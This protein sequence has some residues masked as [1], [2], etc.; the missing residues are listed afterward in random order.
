VIK[1]EHL[2]PQTA[3]HL[4]LPLDVVT[5]ANDFFWRQGVRKN[6]SEANYRSVFVRHLG[7]I[8]ISRYSLREEITILIRKIRALR[9]HEYAQSSHRIA[10]EKVNMET[11]KKLLIKRNELA[12]DYVAAYGVKVRLRPLTLRDYQNTEE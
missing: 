9:N 1:I 10:A 12:K 3:K 5:K 11:L 7:T 2:N 4:N 6:L 8:T